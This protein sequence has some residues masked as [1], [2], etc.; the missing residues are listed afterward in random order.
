MFAAQISRKAVRLKTFF[1]FLGEPPPCDLAEA[2]ASFIA[3]AHMI[4][5]AFQNLRTP[6]ANL[7]TH[8]ERA[9][10]FRCQREPAFRVGSR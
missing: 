3:V 10:S 1:I 4:A 5:V 2:V 8:P 6:Q 9:S 7:K